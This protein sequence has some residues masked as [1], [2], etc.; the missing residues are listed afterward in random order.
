MWTEKIERRLMILS[1]TDLS[2]AQL[3][4]TLNHEFGISCGRMAI[5]GKLKRLRDTGQ[6]MKSPPKTPGPKPK[7]VRKPVKKTPPVV[8]PKPANE[9]KSKRTRNPHTQLNVVHTGEFKDCQ[10]F[11]PEDGAKQCCRPIVGPRL[12]GVHNYCT[13]H[14]IQA[15]RPDRRGAAERILGLS[16]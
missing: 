2:Y 11:G 14:Q 10:W 7:R 3:A 6:L 13:Q 12:M 9:N 5:A 4:E 16:S 8:I 1:G 15:I